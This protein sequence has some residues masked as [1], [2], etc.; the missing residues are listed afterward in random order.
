MYIVYPIL[1]HTQFKALAL[2]PKLNLKVKMN[3]WEGNKW[4]KKII[5]SFGNIQ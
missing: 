2:H 4:R 3:I 1:S 5:T